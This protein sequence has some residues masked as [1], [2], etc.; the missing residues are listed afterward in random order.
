MDLLPSWD[1]NWKRR[2]NS[3]PDDLINN[4]YVPAFAR[5]NT[6][7]R[8]VGF[9]SARLLAAIAPSI[10][11]FVI[12]GGKMRLITSPAHLNDE[13]LE[14]MGKGEQLR[15]RI[16]Q[17]LREAIAKPIPNPVLAD[18]LKLLTW[19]VATGKLDVRIALREHARSYALFHEKI[20]IF[21]DGDGNWMTFT[22]SPNETLGGARLHS[23]SFPLH[24]SWANEEQR[25]YAQEERDRFEQVW[26]EQVEGI[27]LWKVNDW[28]EEPMRST[29]GMREPSVARS[30]MYEF[31]EPAISDIPIPDDAT[32]V[33]SLPDSLVLR[34]YQKSAVNDWLLAGGRGTFAMATGTGKTLTALAAATQASIH[35]AKSDRPLLVL[36]IVPSIDLVGQWR[37]DAERFGFRPAVCHGTLRRGQEEYLKSVFS[38]ARSSHGRRTEMVI[39]TAD[40]L[41]PRSAN[42]GPASDHFLQRQ[43]ARHSGHLLVI[44]DEMHSLGTAARLAALPKNA[45]MTLGLSATPK[46][47]GDEV[48]TD[49]LLEY[50]GKPVLSISIKEA[51]YK[52]QALV[53]Y[54]YL[55]SPIELTEEESRQ[56][57]LIS[58]KI[59]MAFGA[60][61]E[62]AAET[63]IRARTRLIQHATNKRGCLRQL[64][65]GGLRNE[66]HQIIYVAEG[67][68]P[69]SDFFQLDET[70]R[71]LREDFG[72][73]VE[74][75]YG[76]T[77]SERREVLQE[78]LASGDIQALLAMK[79]L[80]EG[81]DIPSAR[82]GVIT[83][84]TQN[85]RQFVQ[86]RG[87]L[88]RRD[89]DN[90]KSH[91]VIHDFLVMP[92]RPVGEPSD[93][94][95]RLIGAELSRA[96]ELADAA[97]NSEALFSVIAWAYE[98][99]LR[100]AEHTWMNLT[101]EGDMEEWV[102]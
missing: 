20:G 36:V 45:T 63:H 76:E 3:P 98:Y 18:R 79:C 70:E 82:I 5:S 65:A 34:E 26:G 49:A 42:M 40:S 74:R 41:T 89:P 47:H 67:K 32:F 16:K 64:M 12:H 80:D 55:P 31:D 102:Q 25:A 39:T 96:A 99:G 75:Y 94:E 58:Q 95:K 50:F 87:R 97:R 52:Y 81:V 4:F 27:S 38:A 10:D 1:P 13:E 71:M 59:A 69:E 101:H 57:R 15:E 88:L 6:Y 73:R 91:A 78:R 28:I 37:N 9:F 24:R 54:D 35:I 72:M 68:D 100:P 19:M 84:S 8:A 2:Y 7:D 77:D 62:Q 86:R 21:A 17:D 22:G 61:D 44:G 43:L 23:E 85:P 33:P 60:G 51:I 14:A 29:F 11:R 30:R 93:S 46:R 83:A 92:P 90:P 48:G 53:P 56:Y 66:T